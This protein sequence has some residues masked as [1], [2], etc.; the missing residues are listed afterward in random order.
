[1]AS[2]LL[3]FGCLGLGLIA[4]LLALVVGLALVASSGSGG[5]R[6]AG[7]GANS[8]EKA[9]PGSGVFGNAETF[10]NKNYAELYS[11]PRAHKGVSVDIAG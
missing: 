5:S 8:Q 10:T 2:R 7:G 6:S 11:N 1:M 4:V 9:G 3:L